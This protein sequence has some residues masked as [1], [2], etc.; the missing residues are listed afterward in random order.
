MNT[1][2]K[3]LRKFI[4]CIFS[5]N[6]FWSLSK[7]SINVNITCTSYSLTANVESEF[8]EPATWVE[9]PVWYTWTFAIYYFYFGLCFLCFK[10]CLWNKWV[11]CNHQL[12]GIEYWSLF[13]DYRNTMKNYFV[14]HRIMS[15]T[16]ANE[17]IKEC[18]YMWDQKLLHFFIP[19]TYTY[20]PTTYCD[21]WTA[22]P[23]CAKIYNGPNVNS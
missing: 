4:T 11:C 17:I 23:V 10:F 14:F 8:Y 19:T 13:L 21:N 5:K 6:V 1:C 22:L 18:S 12:H 3:A 20:L 15:T 16:N 7:V 9:L 2:I